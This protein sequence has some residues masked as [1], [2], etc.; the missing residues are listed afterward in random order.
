VLVFRV[1]GSHSQ[2]LGVKQGQL[3]ASVSGRWILGFNSCLSTHQGMGASQSPRSMVSL[4][5]CR[6]SLQH[7]VFGSSVLIAVRLAPP[8]RF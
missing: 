3:S 7:L 4:W 2:G 8:F 1:V 6:H 5:K